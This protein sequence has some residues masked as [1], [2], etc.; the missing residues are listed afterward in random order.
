[1]M[2]KKKAIILI[3]VFFI[4]SVLPGGVYFFIGEY[5]DAKNYEN[6][7]LSSKPVL[8]T[9]NY[10][11][12]PAEYESYY[13]DNIPFRNQLI[14]LNNSI[15]YFI[16][17]QSSSDNVVIGE[18][19]WLFYKGDTNPVKQSMGYWELFT[20]KQLET[21][22]DNLISSKNVLESMGIEF[23]LFIAPNK[24]TIYREKIPGYYKLK[25]EN[26]CTDQLV[27]YLKE[28]TDIR[29]VYPKEELLQAKSENPGRLLYHKLDT[30]WNSAGGYIGAVS[31]AKELGKDMP[32][33]EE[34]DAEP[35]YN[36]TGDLTNML[37]ISIKDGDSD[38]NISG[39]GSLK[40]ENIKYDFNTEYI[41]HTSG[42]DPRT[43]FVRR[44]S[45]S[46]ALAP[47]I[48]TQFEDSILIRSNSFVQQQIFDYK[49]DIFVYET[50]E[51]FIGGLEQFRISFIS[52]SIEDKDNGMKNIII[53]PAINNTVIN[54]IGNI[55]ISISKKCSTSGNYEQVNNLKLLEKNIKL[56]MPADETGEVCINVYRDKLKKDVLEQVIIKY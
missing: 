36:S 46:T 41:Y 39:T 25:S 2:D 38:Y 29:V 22:A 5:V 26:T 56:Q 7:A 24:E 52:S 16:F 12:F 54:N 40:T 17:K 34:V 31:L 27:K 13:N 14:K 30:H 37:D 20:D 1:M 28:N 50:V 8:T 49:S 10:E 44:D 35:F 51:R 19:G 18:D 6:R 15:D 9:K 3:I 55:Y 53:N 43:L 21:I 11:T 32:L 23:V 33:I 48:A 4:V 47:F 42:A 45:F